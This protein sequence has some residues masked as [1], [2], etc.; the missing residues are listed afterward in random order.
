MPLEI[1]RVNGVERSTHI[2]VKDNEGV[3]YL[4][5]RENLS[6]WMNW[7]GVSLGGDSPRGWNVPDFAKMCIVFSGRSRYRTIK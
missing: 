2:A 6:D 7:R 1:G 3:T 5:P 4:I